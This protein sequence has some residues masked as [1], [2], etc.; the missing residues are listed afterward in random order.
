MKSRLMFSKPASRAER[1][2]PPR[3]VAVL[4]AVELRQLPIVERLH[5]DRDAVEADIARGHAGTPSKGC[6]GSLRATPRRPAQSRTAPAGDEDFRHLLDRVQARRA[7]AEN[8]ISTG[9]PPT[10]FTQSEASLSSG[11]AYD[12]IMC[13]WLAY[14]LKSQ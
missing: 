2:R 14:E 6:L 10:A 1:E 4:D 8:T 5:A 11:P 7:A 12:G 13:S 9:R 3:V